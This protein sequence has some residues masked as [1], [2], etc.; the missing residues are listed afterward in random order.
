MLSRSS[1][2]VISSASFAALSCFC[3]NAQSANAEDPV[4]SYGGASYGINRSDDLEIGAEG[5]YSFTDN[6]QLR[7]TLGDGL[8]V[9]APTFSTST[10]EWR[11]AAGPGLKYSEQLETVTIPTLDRF[12]DEGNLRAEPI[13]GERDIEVED[14]GVDLIGVLTAERAFGDYFVVF[15][16]LNVGEEFSGA[17][18]GGVRF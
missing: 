16:T 11:F 8:F 13:E 1:L 3:F 17:I 4:G 6:F 5:V 14:N 18:G 7:A 10:G 12:D 15:G 2:R 9:I